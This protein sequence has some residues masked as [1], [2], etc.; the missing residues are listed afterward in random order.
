MQLTT[1][2]INYYILIIFVV[3][4]KKER[5]IYGRKTLYINST[6]LN[7]YQLIVLKRFNA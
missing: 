1:F 6:R 5:S 2:E 3:I 7:K 4:S